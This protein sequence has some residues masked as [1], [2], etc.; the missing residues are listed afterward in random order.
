MENAANHRFAMDESNAKSTEADMCF[1][2]MALNDEIAFEQ[3]VLA[4]GPNS[5]NT[6]RS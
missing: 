2:Y 3:A 5:R 1:L 6:S 4:V